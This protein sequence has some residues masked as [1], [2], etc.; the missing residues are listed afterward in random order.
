MINFIAMPK[1]VLVRHGQSVWNLENRFTGNV[2]VDLTPH[3]REEARDAGRKLRGIVF[4]HCFV[5]GLRRAKETLSLILAEGGNA[6]DEM[7]QGS[8]AEGRDRSGVG[9]G[10]GSDSGA[11]AVAPP[12]SSD[13]ALDERSY[14]EL[15]GL[16]KDEMSRKY[17]AEQV[18]TWR[19]SYRVVPPGGESLENTAARVLPYYHAHIEPLLRAGENI[20]VV[21]H[22]NSLRALVMYL[23]NI[24]P[25][26][27]A[28]VN[29]PTGVPRVYTMD[30]ELRVERVEYL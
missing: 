7:R 18:V 20:L 9:A 1:L 19:R 12:V 8:E 16:N 22:G 24:S 21:A 13:K 15:Q 29:L 26:A 25:E 5:S 3:G 14:G 4:D 11:R 27:I 23:E 10:S 30:R 28:D 2:D 6:G 17:G